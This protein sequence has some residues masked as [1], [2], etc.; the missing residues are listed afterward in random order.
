MR[1]H[2]LSYLEKEK[3]ATTTHV[4]ISTIAKQSAKE[5]LSIMEDQK[6]EVSHVIYLNY[7]SLL[8][9]SG[10]ERIHAEITKAFI[11]L[12]EID[13]YYQYYLHDLKFAY[14]I[15][16]NENYKK[17]KEELILLANLDV[18]LLHEYR[19]IFLKRQNVQK[20]ILEK[21]LCVEKD[22]V[23]YHHILLNECSHIQDISCIFYGRG[24][25][26]SDLQFL[27]F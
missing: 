19:K 5:F 17:A 26:L 2:G 11:E 21:E 7:L 3:M 14:E 1:K 18:P 9:L 15:I 20:K 16:Y 22:P 25:L 13:E 6:D 10:S 8:M 12:T 23:R 27:S 24:F 4:N